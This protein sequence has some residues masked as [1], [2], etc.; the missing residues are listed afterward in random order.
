MPR[1]APH[2]ILLG[3]ALLLRLPAC[4]TPAQVVWD[5]EHFSKFTQG[6]LSGR[7]FFDIHPPLG[8]LVLAAAS[9]PFAGDA[10]ADITFKASTDWPDGYP[11]ALPRIVASVISSLIPWLLFLLVRALGL[12]DRA[13]WMAALLALADSALLVTGRLG[14]IDPFVHVFV[15][16]TVV[17]WLH[18]VKA[19]KPA[20]QWTCLLG[21]GVAAGCAI[22]SKWTGLAGLGSVLVLAGVEA[23]KTREWK[24]LPVR[25]ACLAG[26]AVLVYVSCFAIHFS[27]L[28]KS[29]PGDAFMTAPFVATLQGTPESRRPDAPRAGFTGKFLELNQVM[30]SANRQDLKHFESSTFWQWPLGVGKVTFWRIGARRMHLVPNFVVWW[31]GLA[32]FLATIGWLIWRRGKADPVYRRAALVLLLLHLSSWI[33]MWGIA[34]ALFLYHYFTPMLATLGLAGMWLDLQ[35]RS[36][37]WGV[38][39]VAFVGLLILS[40]IV[41]GFA[42]FVDPGL[43]P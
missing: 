34:R 24:P 13:A 11:W 5:E 3:A 38:V 9:A 16:A 10:A 40:P 25:L 37:G 43:P 33:P 23:L 35:P 1:W 32:A 30:F 27:L 19:E 21:A 6:Y 2:A 29:G 17:L 39:I 7:Y 8:K 18:H 42:P 12:P 4:W 26:P 31:S 36:S 14:F 15:L 41:Y 20:W 28:T 22:S